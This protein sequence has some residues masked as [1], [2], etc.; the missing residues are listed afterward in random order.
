ME[1][2]KGWSRHLDRVNQGQVRPVCSLF[3]SSGK[4]IVRNGSSLSLLTGLVQVHYIVGPAV[5]VLAF[6]AL[7][8]SAN[9]LKVLH[10]NTASMSFPVFLLKL[11]PPSKTN[12]HWSSSWVHNGGV[13]QCENKAMKTLFGLPANRMQ[14]MEVIGHQSLDV[15]FDL[16]CQI[17]A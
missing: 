7:L 15:T 8:H 9:L 6:R 3:I 16:Y 5:S 12:K 13:M 2:G 10:L 1:M 11:P 4:L 14:M 17:P